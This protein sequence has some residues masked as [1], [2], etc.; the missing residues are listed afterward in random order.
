MKAISIIDLHSSLP[1]R[2]HTSICQLKV[3]QYCHNDIYH[4]RAHREKLADLVVDPFLLC[5]Y[6]IISFAC[7]IH[8]EIFFIEMHAWPRPFYSSVEET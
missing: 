8:F 6:S 7:T 3:N 2:G 4:A 1:A 5:V